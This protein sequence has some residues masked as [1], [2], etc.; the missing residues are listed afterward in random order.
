MS[1]LFYYLGH[2]Q[3]QPE[4]LVK[5]AIL[6]EEAGFDGIFISEHFNPWVTD[7]GAA[8]FALS[9]LGAIAQAT[10][11]IKLMTGV[12]TPLYRYHPA[13]VAQAAATIDR[14]SNGRFMLGVG[15]GESINEVPL[16]YLFPK[17]K[18]RSERMI[19]ALQIITHLLKGEKVTFDGNYY[20]TKQAK[21]YSPP[22]HFVPTL[23]AAGGPKSAELAGEYA[24]GLIISIKDTK[25]A[26]TNI[27]AP[28]KEKAKNK[29][30]IISSSRWT[31]FARDENEAWEALL[32][33]RGLRA[34]S[35]DSAVDPEDLQKEADTL[36]KSEI[37]SRYTRVSSSQ[38]YIDAYKPLVTELAS[39]I[40]CI[41]T[42][43]VNQEELIKMLGKEVL[44]KL[45]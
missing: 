22:F 3:F 42:T 16:G 4:V 24:D 38:E 44:P 8:G 36:P 25:D 45:K 33:W 39:D 10:K 18:E 21:L 6:A 20:K 17:Y 34:P 11:N 37:L 41:Q 15:T 2:E 32:P 13:V 23:L 27:I 31:V 14:L 29:N 9:T 43:S 7:K 5:H 12:I 19:E 30:F 26:Q 35:R 1:Q 40:V 28:A